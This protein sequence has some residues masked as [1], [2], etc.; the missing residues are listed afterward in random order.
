ML[1]TKHLWSRGDMDRDG[2][3]IRDGAEF[4]K[5]LARSIYSWNAQL[6]REAED[7]IDSVGRNSSVVVEQVSGRV[8]TETSTR[9]KLQRQ[10][11]KLSQMQDYVG[12]RITPRL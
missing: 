11:M 12:V 6:A 5:E 4:D 3:S 8:K 1:D 10:S 7:I 9:Q 2:R